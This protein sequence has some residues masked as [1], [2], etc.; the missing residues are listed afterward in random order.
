[1]FLKKIFIF[2]SRLDVSPLTKGSVFKLLLY[3]FAGSNIIIYTGNDV[4]SKDIFYKDQ[5]GHAICRNVEKIQLPALISNY[6]ELLNPS[7]YFI[8]SSK[9]EFTIFSKRCIEHTGRSPPVY[10]IC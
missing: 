6:F 3:L 1:M 4:S 2:V 7:G 8:F 9:I 5:Q 10:Y